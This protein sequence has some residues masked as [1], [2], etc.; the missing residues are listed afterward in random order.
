MTTWKEPLKQFLG[1]RYVQGWAIF[2]KVTCLY[3][4][5]SHLPQIP[6]CGSLKVLVRNLLDARLPSP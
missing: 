5:F 6:F 1:V 3:L 2:R 4:A